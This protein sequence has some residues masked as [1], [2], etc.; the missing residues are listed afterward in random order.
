[1]IVR[2]FL[3]P[4]TFYMVFWRAG[5]KRDELMDYVREN[6][7]DYVIGFSTIRNFALYTFDFWTM[8]VLF[9]SVFIAAFAG[10][11]FTFTTIDM[12]Q[13]LKSVQRRLSTASYNRHKNAVRSLIAQFATSSLCLVPPLFLVVIILGEFEKAQSG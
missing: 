5:I 9:L 1:M 2:A 12:L 10:L 6:Y 8:L 4:V 11:V 13:M 3:L 7:P